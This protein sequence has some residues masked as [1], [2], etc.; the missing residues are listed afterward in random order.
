MHAMEEEFKTC[1][2][3]YRCPKSQR[4]IFWKRIGIRKDGDEIQSE[5][6]A[7]K[8]KKTKSIG[9]SLRLGPEK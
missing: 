2:H 7:M 6:E 8:T 4:D 5:P 3:H 9:W 1:S